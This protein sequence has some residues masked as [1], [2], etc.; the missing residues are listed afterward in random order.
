MI[1]AATALRRLHP[2]RRNMEVRCEGRARIHYLLL[3]SATNPKISLCHALICSTQRYTVMAQTK[4]R[5]FSQ[6]SVW[7]F[8]LVWT[9]SLYCKGYNNDLMAT[10]VY[11]W[12]QCCVFSGAQSLECFRLYSCV[13]EHRILKRV[14]VFFFSFL[15]QQG[16]S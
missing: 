6:T 13:V 8:F 1:S 15:L 16:F 9:A 2:T 10:N 12:Q 14:V 5:K 4:L 3:G 11:I 7:L